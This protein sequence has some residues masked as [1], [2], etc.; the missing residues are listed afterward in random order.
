VK[1]WITEWDLKR[2]APEEAVDLEVIPLRPSYTEDP[3][4]ETPT[5]GDQVGVGA[6]EY[7]APPEPEYATTSVG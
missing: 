1:G 6:D 3:E 4:L 2:L 7:S 5:E